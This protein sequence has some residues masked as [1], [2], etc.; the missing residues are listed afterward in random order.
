MYYIIPPS[1]RGILRGAENLEE[2]EEVNECIPGTHAS[3]R[4]REKAQ[5]GWYTYVQLFPHI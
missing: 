4:L 5:E 2:Q 3:E 1:E